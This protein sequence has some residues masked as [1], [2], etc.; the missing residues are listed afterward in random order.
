MVDTDAF[1]QSLHKRRNSMNYT[2]PEVVVLGEAVRVIEGTHIKGNRGIIEAI[3]SYIL[4]A[5]DLD[6]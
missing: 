6:D 4:P 3:R 2:K 1:G 5:Y